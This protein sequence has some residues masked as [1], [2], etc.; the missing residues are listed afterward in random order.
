MVLDA[1]HDTEREE[2]KPAAVELPAETTALRDDASKEIDQKEEIDGRDEEG[3]KQMAKDA[4]PDEAEG[5]GA[6]SRLRAPLAAEAGAN[7]FYDYGLAFEPK[8]RLALGGEYAEVGRRVY[9]YSRPGMPGMIPPG[10]DVRQSEWLLTLFPSLPE[11]GSA[12]GS[13]PSWSAEAQALAQSL[14]RNEK[15][16]KMQGGLE[17]VQ[18]TESFDVRWGD[19][20]ARSRLIALLSAGAWLTRAEDDA[21]ATLINWCDG[22][23]RGVLSR[24]FQLG[25]IRNSVPGDLRTPSVDLSDYSLSPLD[26]S[27]YSYVATLEPQ[28]DG[29]TLLV[30]KH[31]SSSYYETRV[32]VDTTRHVVV[33][34]EQ[35][36]NGK[37]TTTTLFDDF[38]E[39]G[40]CWWARKIE[41]TDDRGRV[42]SR[43]SHTIKA[44][45]ADALTKQVHNELAARESVQF[46][47]L[48]RKS[49]AEA[50]KAV[51]DKKATF[52]DH[53]A[54]LRYF[55]GRQQ[56]TRVREQ[57]QKCEDLAAGKLGVR[58][59]RYAVLLTSRRHE[60]LRKQMLDEAARLARAKTNDPA[61]SDD[62]V[63]AEYIVNQAVQI[64]Q[65]N[66]MLALLDQLKPIY[67]RQ[68]GHQHR[69]KHWTARR[70]GAMQQTGQGD[71]ALRLQKQLASQWPH[72]ATL[73]HQYAQAL[74][75]SGDYPAAY[76]W[77]KAA[78]EKP[79]RWLA[80]ED[81]SLRGLYAQLLEGQGRYPELVDY[82]A[83]WIQ[84]DP[85][86]ASVSAQYLSALIRS[87]RMDAV[88]A[89]VLRWLR[90]ARTP[91]E[92]KLAVLAR[93]SRH[94][95][96]P[97]PGTQLL[98]RPHRGALGGSAGRS[99]LGFRPARRHFLACRPNSVFGAVRANRRVPARPQGVAERPDGPPRQTAA[100]PH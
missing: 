23:E 84:H 61:G 89:A 70:L 59:L 8:A 73:Q 27:Y 81:D 49:I 78:L 21:Q 24:P 56:W 86:N 16:A 82:L 5:R 13:K 38:V 36:Q 32:L 90:E 3:E 69:M 66:E 25:S 22:R 68:P 29:R 88:D 15:L 92:I 14:L 97:R 34:V 71:E 55:A 94:L 47:H 75:S 12:K 50:K 1:L 79:A 95:V 63:L 19:L 52:D 17:I 67:E 2:S 39:V 53:F 44:L 4:A 57:L 26:Q 85:E 93:A 48:P 46:L 41:T 76:A 20:T 45:S 80:N 83:D 40:G 65:A 43:I 7:E 96:R 37:R 74:A 91:G 28:K 54:L 98:H 99:R 30:L 64:L 9:G 51:A 42:S 35:L 31:P 60:A 100:P 6:N 62:V 11:T 72:D 77:L 33:R 18:Q 10:W 87:D 58:W